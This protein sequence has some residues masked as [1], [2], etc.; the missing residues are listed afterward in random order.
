M[1]WKWKWKWKALTVAR[2]ELGESLRSRRFLIFLVLYVGGAAGAT[3]IFTEVLQEV[4]AA[5]AEQ[6]LVARTDTPGS[7]TQAVM[8]SPEL[9]RVLQRLLRDDRLA[10]AL[11]R[12]PPVALLYHWVALSFGPIF[13]ALTSSDVISREIS[14]GSVRFALVRADRVS[15]MVGKL[16]GQSTLLAMSLALGA[17]ATW[18]TGWAQLG[19]FEPLLT[20]KWLLHFCLTAYLFNW[21]HLGLVL[22]ISQLTRSVPWS[23]A[24]GLLALV[25]V[26]GAHR[27]LER[28]VVIERAP[29]LAGSLRQLFPVAH[30]LDLWRPSLADAS[31]SLVLLFALGVLYLALGYLR[32]HRRDA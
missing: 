9:L 26:F 23:R 2:F 3:V 31:G 5:L 1:K 12:V 10:S 27:L 32:L 17:V 24:L 8:E 18:M 13:V 14:T 21:A 7:L 16:I 11:V 29:V 22:G 25:A 6:L 15:W 30:R 28:D 4:E 19:S 20:A